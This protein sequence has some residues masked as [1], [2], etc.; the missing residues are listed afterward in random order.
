MKPSTLINQVK[1][2]TE[3]TTPLNALVFN[4]PNTK[5]KGG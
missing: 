3:S 4:D 2:N 1:L 5:L